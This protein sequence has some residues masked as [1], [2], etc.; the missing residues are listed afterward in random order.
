[1]TE[2]Q[3]SEREII[4]DT[5]KALTALMK[6][7]VEKKRTYGS[8][9]ERE[10]EAVEVS[11]YLLINLL[12]LKDDINGQQNLNPLQKDRYRIFKIANEL[13]FNKKLI[14]LQKQ[15]KDLDIDMYQ[16]LREE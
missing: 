12:F 6:I 3:K 15:D 5:I 4:K 2:G 8:R 14:E 9:T 13:N 10:D 16:L 1:M 7:L 11:K